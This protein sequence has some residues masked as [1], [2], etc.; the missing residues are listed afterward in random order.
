MKSKILYFALIWVVSLT[1][2]KSFAQIIPVKETVITGLKRPWSMV[3]ITK[4]DVLL[5]EKEGNLLRINLQSK[6][7][8]IIKGFPSDLVDS[9]DVNYGKGNN[10]GIFEV[11]IDPN[12]STNQYLYLSYAAQTPNEGTTTKVIR[13]TIKN[14]S[15][16]QI[17]TLLIASPFTKQ[18]HHYGGGL[19]FGSDQ[20]L[21]ITIGERLFYEIDEPATPIA[22]D[23]T[24]KRGKIY[25]IN[26]DGSIPND[27]PDFGKNAVAGLYALGIRA[28]QGMAIHPETGDIWFSEHGTIQGDEINILKAGVN[29]G[30]PLVTSGQYRSKDYNP[31]KVDVSTLT[32]PIWYWRQTVAPT[33]LAFYTGKEFPVWRNNLFVPGLSG[34]SLW[35]F[36]LE[37]EKVKSVE[38]LFVD[39]PVRLRKVVQS[40]D[41]KLYLLTDELD[42][43]IIRI[44]KP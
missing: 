40:P 9:L 15:L 35:R 5:T 6:R 32:S 10:S 25:R 8:T 33:G 14:D 17:K 20:K 28:A 36:K 2:T 7:K 4:N 37:N 26:P 12:F 42:G 27:N 38:Q 39:D 44:K 3:F 41:G 24:D 13:A 18:N 11:V 43:K 16:T 19:K 29:Y 23:P 22:Q 1:F 34:G 30:W 31:P 21:Y